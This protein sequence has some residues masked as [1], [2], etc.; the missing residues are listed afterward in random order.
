MRS[1]SA[2]DPSP[3]RWH[4]TAST[5][6]GSGSA[7]LTAADTPLVIA[8]GRLTSNKGPDLLVEAA[9]QLA[10]KVAFRVAFLGDGPMRGQLEARTRELGVHEI[11]SFAGQ[12]HDVPARMAEADIVIRA[13]YTEGLALAVIEGM[14]AGRCNIVSDI[15]PN[16][17]LITDGDN[18]LTF[19]AGDAADLARALR[20]AIEDPASRERG[21]RRRRSATPTR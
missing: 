7:P 15:P 17:E 8:V 9:G 19:R 4:P 1:P 12:V 3:S 6:S 5:T 21:P 13:S 16:L 10:S 20:L 14:A 11:V 18:G 2:R